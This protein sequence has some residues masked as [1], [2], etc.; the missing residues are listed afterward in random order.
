MD[1]YNV[2][3]RTEEKQG[4][5]PINEKK[6]NKAVLWLL[7]WMLDK[8][9]LEKQVEGYDSLSVGRASRKVAVLLLI[10]SAFIT[11]LDVVFSVFSR[12]A[13]IDVVFMLAIAFFIYQG[14]RWAMILA[15]LYWTCA[16]LCMIYI[17]FDIGTI[18]YSTIGWTVYM[19]VFYEAFKVEQLRR[20]KSNSC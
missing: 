6:K 4:N 12:G 17:H 19:H 14:H 18:L 5:E 11:T 13:L 8:D 9:V 15:M 16:R 7:W 20:E 2:S 3:Q 1:S 10:L